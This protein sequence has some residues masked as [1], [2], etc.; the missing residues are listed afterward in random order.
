[1]FC[2]VL[3]F[4]SAM[5]FKCLPFLHFC[6]A[7]SFLNYCVIFRNFCYPCILRILI[8]SA[9]FCNSFLHL[10]ISALLLRPDPPPTLVAHGSPRRPRPRP[11]Q[12]PF[13]DI[14]DISIFRPIS[15]EFG[16]CCFFPHLSD[17]HPRLLHPRL[18][19]PNLT[20]TTKAPTLQRPW[21]RWSP[22]S[23][24]AASR[25]RPRTALARASHLLISVSVSV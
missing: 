22:W 24:T 19:G 2:K 13:I 1:M 8:L 10:C 7:V 11:A 21:Q 17:L 6:L 9:L 15:C 18:F 25:A 23:A 4:C 14:S 12:Q 5:Q 16:Q 3:H 20:W